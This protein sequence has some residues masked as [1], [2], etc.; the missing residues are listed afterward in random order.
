MNWP[1]KQ[2]TC[3]NAAAKWFKANLLLTLGQ[4]R[5]TL[6]RAGHYYWDGGAVFG[7]VPKTMWSR[8]MPADAL[9]RVPL[10][11]NCYVIETG[12]NTVLL[13][14]GGGHHFSPA[15]RERMNL[16]VLR[17]L[18]ELLSHFRIDTVI[19]THLHWDHCSG[20]MLDGAPAFPEARYFTSAAEYEHAHERNVRD[21]ISYIDDNYDPLVGSCRM[22]LLEGNTEVVPGI[23][24]ET[25]PGHNRDMMIVKAQSEGETF[26][27]L[28]DLVPTAEHL[29]PTWIAA[30][31]L[32]PLTA[33][34][35]KLHLLTEAAQKNWWCGFGHDMRHAFATVAED[36]SL[37][38]TRPL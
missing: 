20:N 30:F 10:A 22:E 38:E 2:P 34:E 7:V 3:L 8:N 25:A 27:L 32:Y 16:P 33:I 24:L 29:K 21:S 19:N 23:T 11:F 1:K 31:D 9:N 37:K 14:T 35:T 5:I 17:P 26:C 12:R 18:P 28:A 36:F 15:S 6:V 13:E 4:F